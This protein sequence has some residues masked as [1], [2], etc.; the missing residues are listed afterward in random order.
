MDIDI[1]CC[2]K[3]QTSNSAECICFI[4][5]GSANFT[6]WNW[7]LYT[8]FLMFLLSMNLL[9]L[10]LTTEWI[11]TPHWFLILYFIQSCVSTVHHTR[12]YNEN[13]TDAVRVIDILTAYGVLVSIMILFWNNLLTYVLFIIAGSIIILLRISDNMHVKSFVH[14]TFHL[15]ISVYILIQSIVNPVHQ[16]MLYIFND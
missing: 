1:L 12:T 11:Q 9:I 10:K 4:F 15:V 16:D 14:A 3:H 13:Y 2:S 8:A 5:P 6:P 7:S